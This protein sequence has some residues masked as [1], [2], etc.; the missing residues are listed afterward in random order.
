MRQSH[1]TLTAMHTSMT[2]M[3]TTDIINQL[4]EEIQKNA[5]FREFSGGEL[6][7]E[8]AYYGRYQTARGE[9]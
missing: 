3:F 4:E 6:F 2:N 9:G 7:S 1:Q 8:C 5:E